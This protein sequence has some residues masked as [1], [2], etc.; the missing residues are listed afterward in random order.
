MGEDFN[1]NA[2]IVIVFLLIGAVRWV[3]ENFG[4]KNQPTERELWEEQNHEER[5]DYNQPKKSSLEDLYEEARREILER[6]NQPTP[7]PEVLQERRNN[8]RTTPPPPPLP[9][10]APVVRRPPELK[11]SKPATP[12][13]VKRQTLSD[14]EKKA[15]AAFEKH[16]SQKKNK[17]SN[18]SGSKVRDLLK[19]SSAARDA[20]LLTEILGRPKGLQ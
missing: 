8:S 14:E 17:S 13:K 3:I 2:I 9:N 19:T 10:K 6:Q 12:P 4:K 11:T 1:F 20:V 18:P 16:S 7:P 5:P 15:A